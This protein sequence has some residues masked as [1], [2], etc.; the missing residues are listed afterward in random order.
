MNR[1][2]NISL[3]MFQPTPPLDYN[4]GVCNKNRGGVSYSCISGT[5]C[6]DCHFFNF[7]E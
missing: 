3:N 2:C 6:S 5:I 1:G 4:N 7:V